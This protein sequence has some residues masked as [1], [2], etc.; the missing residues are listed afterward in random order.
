MKN[1][2]KEKRYEALSPFEL[3]NK[4]LTMAQT[5]HERMM[6]DA[7]GGNPNWTTMTPRQVSAQ[8]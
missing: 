2:E 5:S 1:S 4:L 6:L 3:K 7:G 8:N